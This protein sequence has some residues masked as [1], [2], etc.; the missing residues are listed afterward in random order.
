M[1]IAIV[2]GSCQSNEQGVTGTEY[3]ASRTT[4]GTPML[5][6]GTTRSMWPM[7]SEICGRAGIGAEIINLAVGSTGMT[8]Y[9][10]GACRT[11]V[12]SIFAQTG[13]YVLSGGKIWKCTDGNTTNSNPWGTSTVT[14]SASVGVDN[15]Q[16]SDLG[17]PTAEDT[18]GRIYPRTSPRFDPNGA[19]ALSRSRVLAL[20][21]VARR[22][23]IISIADQSSG[24]TLAEYQEAYTQ[25]ARY[26]LEAGIE[27]LAGLTVTGTT[28]GRAEWMRDVADPAWQNVCSA[29]SGV[30]G[31]HVGVNLFRHF[32]TTSDLVAS[33]LQVATS[34]TLGLQSDQ[35]HMNSAAYNSA[36]R[37]WGDRIVAVCNG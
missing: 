25:Q 17:T 12:S 15:V 21:G 37:A 20:P 19:L 2:T 4:Y 11:W 29:L 5:D 10:T 9:W 26:F 7:V 23:A 6:L 35:L 14:P 16:W 36:A 8:G 30:S 32:A 27:V 18:A 34:P 28:A 13:L 22:F 31:F 33:N 24:A 1:R 3:G